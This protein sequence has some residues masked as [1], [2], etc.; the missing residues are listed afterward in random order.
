MVTQD[1]AKLRRFILKVNGMDYQ[2][3]RCVSTVTK[4]LEACERV[5]LYISLSFLPE[6]T[7]R[8]DGRY[9]NQHLGMNQTYREKYAMGFKTT[10]GHKGMK[11]PGRGGSPKRERANLKLNR[12]PPRLR[13]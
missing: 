10:G 5:F 2:Q 13:F 6:M 1:T 9:H 11:G 7:H 4:W 8:I 12:S 3:L